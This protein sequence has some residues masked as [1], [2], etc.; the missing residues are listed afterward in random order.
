MFHRFGSAKLIPREIWLPSQ[1]PRIFGCPSDA[2]IPS[3]NQVARFPASR[4]FV[5]NKDSQEFQV[6]GE[7]GI[8][9]RSIYGCY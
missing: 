3:P 4:H 5:E 7:T 2:R 1:L 9:N 6:A 8:V